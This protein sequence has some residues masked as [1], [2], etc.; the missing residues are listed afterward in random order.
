MGGEIKDGNHVDL[1]ISVD[2]EIFAVDAEGNFQRVDTADENGLQG[3]K[4][5]KVSFQDLEIL[6]AEGW[7]IDQRKAMPPTMAIRLFTATRPEMP[8]IFFS[9]TSAAVF[10][11]IIA[12]FTM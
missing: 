1:F 3:G 8:S 4:S 11:I 5:T 2:I 6:K 12:L 10:S 7:T 9:L